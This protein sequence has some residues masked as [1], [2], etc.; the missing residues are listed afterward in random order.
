M[1]VTL[2]GECQQ[3]LPSFDRIIAPLRY[4]GLCRGLIRKAKFENQPHLLRPLV[5]FIIDHLIEHDIAL[6]TAWCVVPTSQQSLSERGYCQTTLIADLLSKA[7][8]LASMQRIVLKRRLEVSA[9]H[10]RSKAE[11]HSLSHRLFYTEER[12]PEQV[13][14]I[15]DVV[16][17]GSTAEACA[18]A[19]RLAGAKRVTVLALA[20]TSE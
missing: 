18:K 8:T 20:R 12:V 9:Q 2:C 13:L 7:P 17:T 4:E 15:D 14:L 6:P 3:T 11:R 1:T 16:T 5:T 10:T 19:L